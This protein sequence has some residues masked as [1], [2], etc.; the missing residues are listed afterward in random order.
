MASF[1][2]ALTA[3]SFSTSITTINGSF[4]FVE[5]RLNG[6]SMPTVSSEAARQAAPR[7]SGGIPHPGDALNYDPLTL[8][9]VL[10][11]SMR[12]HKQLYTWLK[13]GVIYNDDDRTVDQT[14]EITVHAFNLTGNTTE[15]IIFKDAFPTVVNG[16][17][18]TS[19]DTGDTIVSFDAT[20]EYSSF[21]YV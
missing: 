8:T 4:P 11:G 16:W 6:F 1:S 19:T 15:S 5:C 12:V 7:R 3:T 18:F 10:D 13:N 14:A 9:F 21:E 2:D 20:F 17:N